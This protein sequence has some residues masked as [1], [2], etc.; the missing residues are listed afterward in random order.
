MDLRNQSDQPTTA[1]AAGAGSRQGGWKDHG[2]PK[3]LMILVTVLAVFALIFALV[4]AYSAV[5]SNSSVKSSQ[6]QALFLTNGQVYFGHLTHI[7]SGYV[8]LTDIYYLQVQQTVQP[9]SGT[10]SSTSSAANQNVSLTKLGNEIHGPEDQMFV[11]RSQVLF[12]ENL[13]NSGKVVTAIL[14][15]QK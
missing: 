14:N 9:T 8:E 11:S 15:S 2:L 3:V 4:K 6:F 7:N 13:K 1:R 12:W 5:T 10:S